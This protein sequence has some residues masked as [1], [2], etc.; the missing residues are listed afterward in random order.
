M[1]THPDG[2]RAARPPLWRWGRRI[3]V[4]VLVL[5]ILA[6][7]SVGILWTL[8]P[9]VAD[10]PQRVSAVLAAHHAPA[11][12]ALPSPNPVGEAIIA[13]ENS[14][15]SSD[16]GLDPI[17]VLRTAVTTLTGSQDQGAATLEIQMGKNLYTPHRRGLTSKVEQVELAFK[18]DASFTKDQIL[19]MYLNAAYFGHGFYGLAAAAEGYFATAPTELSWAQASLLAGLVQAPS[20]YDPFRNLGLAQS[21]Q[22]H[23]LDRLVSTG[24]LTKSEAQ[25][26]AT[27]P[28]NLR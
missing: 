17:S 4:A 12:A 24:V 2:G 28:L 22:H 18:L 6:V 19:L 3:L 21:R 10:A 23:V 15:F 16:F 9:S 26:A 20:V 14:R 1:A 27:A 25:A 5:A 13:T 8:T 7:G 11:L